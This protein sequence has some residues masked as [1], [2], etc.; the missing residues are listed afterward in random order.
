MRHETRIPGLRRFFRLPTSARTLAA[1]IDEEIRYHLESRT[2]ELTRRG[3]QPAAAREQAEREYGDI[4][5]SRQEI[6]QVDRR[7]FGRTRRT[8]WL[9]DLRQD[10]RHA[11]RGLRRTPGFTAV[12]VLTLALGI[13][14][15]AIIFGIVD[16]LLLRSPAHVKAADEVV[17]IYFREKAPALTPGGGVRT[18]PMASYAM[19]TALQQEVPSLESVAGVSITWP[20][21]MGRGPEAREV[22]VSLVT[23]NYFPLLGVRPALGRFFLPEE[24]RESI[25]TPVAV[26]SHNFWRRHFGGDP[27][28]VGQQIRLSTKVFTIVGVAPPGFSGIDLYNVDVWAPVS[29]LA[30]EDSGPD[31]ATNPGSLWIRAIGRMKP[32]A[33]PDRVNM[34]ATLVLRRKV[35]EWN[36]SWRD[37]QGQAVSGPLIAARGP[38]GAPREAKVSLWLAAVS[39][40]VLLVACANVA[41]LLLARAVRRRREIAV[42]L[43]LGIRGTRLVRQLLT[44][45]LLLAGLAAAA[46]LLLAWWGGH[47]LRSV[48]LPSIA[49]GGSPVHLRVLTFTA[50]VTFA[51]VLLTGLVPALQAG[52]TDVTR[53]LKSGTREGGGRRSRL[54]TGLLVVQAALSVV[55]LVGA[56]LFVQS[57]QRARS[58]DVGIDLPRVL[59]VRANLARAGFDSAQVRS[60]YAAA[61]ERARHLPGVETVALAGGSVPGWSGDAMGVRAA[62]RDSLPPLPNG[63]PYHSAVSADYFATLGA[64]ILRGR[65]LT[66]AEERSGA[67]VVVV[68]ETVAR[69][70]WPGRNPVGE[71]L[72]LGKDNAC[73]EV[74]G[75]V[76][77]VMLFQMIGDER[78]LLYLPLAHPAMASEE[79]SALLVRVRENAAG[80]PVTA[81]LRRELQALSPNMPYVGV[82]PFEAL[83]APELQPWR[84]GATM[85]SVFG[86]LALVIAAVGLYSVLAY[87]V[88]WRFHEIGVRMAL[89]ATAR[90]VVR[91][92]VRDGM[93]VAA[94][95]VAFGALLA[96]AAGPWVESLLY[97]TSPRDPLILAAVAATLLAVA[98]AASLVPAWRA[99]RVNPS[100]ALRAE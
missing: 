46:A 9:D 12:V 67:R 89:G 92:I 27:N 93:R 35:Q 76:Q 99:S 71:C 52:A 64:R 22:D 3:M 94:A 56:G 54:R 69:H 55:L 84:L 38:A 7:R 74:V 85:F 62:G 32:G 23:G 39:G 65:G 4:T 53:A 11:A 96:L 17:R 73:S 63:G 41:N 30:A 82:Q 40:V 18:T 59:L 49:W 81:A 33:T 61:A 79:P 10:L 36:Q 83:V 87:A 47:A 68:N 20:H 88:S 51:T 75:V 16:R 78:G 72:M 44:E 6:E 95:G 100:V 48:L 13:G 15:N 80:A 37:P 21:T 86:V 34:E 98:C 60:L 91:L 45:T 25:G 1:D 97:Q 14:A 8:A 66:E 42:R 90:D 2:E 70:Y 19:I 5:A 24:D 77:N 28:A 57:L 50:A 31:W 29:A 43:A 58:L 26:V